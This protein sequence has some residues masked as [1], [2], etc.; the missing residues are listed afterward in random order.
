MKRFLTI[1]FASLVLCIN[2][3]AQTS[4]QSVIKKFDSNWGVS[5]M[6]IEGGMMSMA[7]GYIKK[8]PMGP[9]ADNVKAATIVTLRWA[10]NQTKT[11]FV[12]AIRQ[13]LKS[14]QFYGTEKGIDGKLVE[15]YGSP[16]KNEVVNEL[17]VFNPVNYSLFSLRGSYSVAE[18]KELA[19]KKQGALFEQ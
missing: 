17:V 12:Q 5:V 6:D 4:I 14:Y 19:P 9:L 3:S 10:S 7:R 8:S 2:L 15:V 18:L 11:E 16:I 13:T 1:I